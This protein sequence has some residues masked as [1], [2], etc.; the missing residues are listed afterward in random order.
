MENVLIN[1]I[2]AKDHFKYQDELIPSQKI[3]CNDLKRLI[4]YK[5]CY[6]QS[7]SHGFTIL[8]QDISSK[9]HE[10]FDKVTAKYKIGS[11]K[12]MEQAYENFAEW[13]RN[14]AMKRAER[15][16]YILLPSLHL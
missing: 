4:Y 10:F 7:D 13:S 6:T 3:I 8:D 9:G 2:C 1:F 16:T 14:I 11:V 15:P 12:K 5:H